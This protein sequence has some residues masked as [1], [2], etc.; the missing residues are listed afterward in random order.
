[1][2]LRAG[3]PAEAEAVYR[4]DLAIWREN[5]WS[6]MG[7]RDALQAQGRAPEAREADARLRKAWANA[8]VKPDASCYCQAGKIAKR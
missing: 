8:D 7:L 5:G 6:L 3:K 1:V 4:A 2:L